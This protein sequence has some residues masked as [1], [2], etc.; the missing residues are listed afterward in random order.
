MAIDLLDVVR[1]KSQALPD[2]SASRIQLLTQWGDEYV[3]SQPI[4]PPAPKPTNIIPQQFPEWTKAIPGI[5]AGDTALAAL[6]G[7]AGFALSRLGGASQLINSAFQ[8]LTGPPGAGDTRTWKQ[9]VADMNADAAKFHYEPR[10]KTGAALTSALSAPLWLAEKYSEMAEQAALDQGW[11]PDNAIA[12]KEAYNTAGMLLVGK[13]MDAAPRTLSAKLNLFKKNAQ[14]KGLSAPETIEAA[15]VVNDAVAASPEISS[16]IAEAKSQLINPDSLW[17]QYQKGVTVGPE[18]TQNIALKVGARLKG[19]GFELDQ[20]RFNTML[21]EVDTL[22]AESVAAGENKTQLTKRVNE[23]Y[24]NTSDRMIGEKSVADA[25]AAKTNVAPIAEILPEEGWRVVSED[26]TTTKNAEDFGRRLLPELSKNAPEGSRYR[27]EVLSPTQV[28]IVREVRDAAAQA[29]EMRNVTPQGIEEN[30]GVRSKG[31]ADEITAGKITEESVS[32]TPPVGEMPTIARPSTSTGETR[33]PKADRMQMLEQYYT[34]GEIVPSYGKGLDKV[35]SFTP[36]EEGKFRVQVQAVDEAGNPLPGTSP[37]FHSTEP[38][39]REMRTVFSQ[40]VHTEVTPPEL[41]NPLQQ[42][43]STVL[44]KTA[45]KKVRGEAIAQVKAVAREGLRSNE[46]TEVGLR[47]LGFTEEQIT[48]LSPEFKNIRSR[49]PK[50]SRGESTP[51]PITDIIRTDEAPLISETPSRIT[52]SAPANLAELE[53]SIKSGNITGA[54][55]ATVS[56]IQIRSSGTKPNAIVLDT[57]GLN[58]RT[59]FEQIDMQLERGRI[60]PEV[61]EGMK[62]SLNRQADIAN[63]PI[64]IAHNYNAEYIQQ[65]AIRIAKENNLE[66]YRSRKVKGEVI[67]EKI[68]PDEI[69]AL[70]KIANPEKGP[71]TKAEADAYIASAKKPIGQEAINDMLKAVEEGRDISDLLPPGVSEHFKDMLEARRKGISTNESANFLDIL[72]DINEAL[73][74][75]GA[76]FTQLSNAQKMA[77]QRLKAQADKAG[78]NVIDL[79]R[80]IPRAQRNMPLFEEYT[81]HINNPAPPDAITPRNLRI[82]EAS[83]NDPV[84]KHRAIN[85]V[86]DAAP[87]YQSEARAFQNAKNIKPAT[88]AFIETP[89]RALDRAG[90][91]DPVL[92]AYR[93][94]QQQVNQ[95]KVALNKDLAQ[96]SKEFDSY[97]R[98][99]IGAYGYA[100]ETQ[101]LKILQRNKVQVPQLN[102]REMAAYNAIRGIYKDFFTRINEVR[103]AVGQDP[104]MEVP[105]YFTRM[106]TFSMMERLGIQGNLIRDSERT[107]ENRFAKANSLDFPYERLRK[108]ATYSAEFDAF[109]IVSRYAESANKQIHMAPF[110]AKMHELLEFKLPDPKTG[111]MT[112]RFK[113]HKPDTYKVLREWTNDLATGTNFKLPQVV[114][115]PLRVLTNNLVYSLLSGGIRSSL[116]QL[117]AIRNTQQAIGPRYTFEGIKASLGDA[118]ANTGDRAF[119]LKNSKILDSRKMDASYNDVT[120]AFTSRNPADLVRMMGQGRIGELQRG[121]GQAGLKLL[122]FFDNETAVY[123]WLGAHKLATEKLSLKGRNA[124]NFADDIVVKTQ[125]S[126]MPGDLAPIQRSIGGRALTQ[127]QTFVISDFNF[128]KTDVLGIGAETKLTPKQIAGRIAQFAVATTALNILLEDFAHIQSPFP[129]PIRDLRKPYEA[130]DASWEIALKMAGRV[131][132]SALETVPVIGSLR[133]GEGPSGPIINTTTELFRSLRGDP[134]APHPLEP[135]AKIAGIPATQQISKTVRGVERGESLY[136]SLTGWYTQQDR[137]NSSP[138]RGSRSS[139]IRSR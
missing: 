22:I 123:T 113:D 45:D 5:E 129:T 27:M 122:E 44:D 32:G 52:Y 101:G 127:F 24:R 72:R 95:A 68:S 108:S 81:K 18:G 98:E 117:T 3:A 33:L 80:Q 54:E 132:A 99:R 17:E 106:R 16:K 40:R 103:E 30:L 28:R 35:I 63:S 6:G 107:I 82:T 136:D 46:A 31:G 124:F 13:G 49:K 120:N 137:E 12:L 8:K 126:S 94:A 19:K 71:I 20:P 105:E 73:G 77:L 25:E 96:M 89:V 57:T 93:A 1:S 61:A 111:E 78:Q 90:L 29:P 48:D 64:E 116:V 65:E 114:E 110:I 47:K 109:R 60:S 115:R 43:I 15:K 51:A 135:I 83:A 4:V 38:N 7:T 131:G 55:S 67:Y 59:P 75:E 86:K 118:I 34:P 97:S 138:R 62:I 36:G 128:L 139:Y 100:Q 41:V 76:V 112:W 84:V 21:N 70:D 56:P 92:H 23:Y 69:N 88:F 58:V 9:F 121:V 85:L 11:S 87:I 2:E 53:S 42:A 74:E 26:I 91:T 130:D 66:V 134:L 10:T 14:S 104:L 37:R 79:L 50:A 133:Y 39:A 125:G 102:A 119:A